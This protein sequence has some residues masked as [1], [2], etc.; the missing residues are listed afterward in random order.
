MA[1]F[2]G[3]ASSPVQGMPPLSLQNRCRC[4]PEPGVT[5]KDVLLV[6]GEQIGFDNIRKNS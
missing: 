6:V 5:V 4:V 2:D 3:M 1:W